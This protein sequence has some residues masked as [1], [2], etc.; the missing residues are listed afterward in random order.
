[1][2]SLLCAGLFLI[3]AA[4]AYLWAG[5]HEVKTVESSV[6]VI[7]SL[8]GIPLKGIPRSLLQESTAVAI[9]PHVV[10]GGLL[11]DAHFGRGVILR[12][13]PD[14]RWSNP[15]FVTLSGEG[16]GAQAGVE[17]TDLVLVFKTPKSLERGLHGKLVLGQDVA[18][19][20]GPLGREAERA[21]DRRLLRAEIYSYSRSRGL[22]AGVSLEGDRLHIDNAANKT[23]YGVREGHAEEVLGC[24]EAPI[25]SAEKLKAELIELSGK[26]L[27]PPPVII[28][29][30]PV[31]Q[32]RHP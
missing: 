31:P 17:A 4:P 1:M 25:A 30:P 2:R 16:I 13:E 9:I 14:G 12:H 27:P 22:F 15:V 24:R 7:H 10:K 11:L 26:P 29:G 19:A 28:P 20:A 6:E 23:F 21:T 18:I 3:L 8:A 32:P 5:G